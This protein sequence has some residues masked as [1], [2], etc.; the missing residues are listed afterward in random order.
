MGVGVRVLGLKGMFETGRPDLDWTL[1]AKRM[2]VPGT[3]VSSLD[4]FGKAL[5]TGL[6]GEGPTLIEVPL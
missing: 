6:A 3:G 4:S 5:R 1:L 2:G